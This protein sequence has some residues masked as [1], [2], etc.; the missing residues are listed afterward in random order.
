MA[1]IC[2]PSDWPLDIPAAAAIQTIRRLFCGPDFPADAHLQ[3]HHTATTPYHLPAAKHN[4]RQSMQPLITPAKHER[5]DISCSLLYQTPHLATRHTNGP[6]LWHN[7]SHQI[8]QIPQ[9]IPHLFRQASN[10][11]TPPRSSSRHPARLIWIPHQTLHLDTA[12]CLTTILQQARLDTP[13][14]S[15]S[16]YLTRLLI[17]TPCQASN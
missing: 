8:S 12:Q 5:A 1:G 10:I 11:H 7:I 4:Y 16:K 17:Q 13:L 2:P 3:H 15:S 9:Q 6:H 14:G